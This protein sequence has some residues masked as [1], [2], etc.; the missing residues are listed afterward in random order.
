MIFYLLAHPSK[1]ISGCGADASDSSGRGDP[2]MK[3]RVLLAVNEFPLRARLARVLHSCGYVAALAGGARRE[4]TR[5]LAAAIVAPTSFDDNGLA[6]ARKLCA[7]GC[8]VIV[9]TD[10]HEAAQTGASILPDAHAFL[11]QPVDEQRL[12]ALL[13]E[14]AAA[15]A[16]GGTAPT[17]V[18]RFEGRSLDLA[19][20]AFVDENGR[21][22]PLTHSEFELLALFARSSGQVL[23]RDQLR[24]GV[25][26][27]DLE[28]YDRSI[29]V[30]VARLRRKIEPNAKSPRFILTLPGVGYK[31]APRVLQAD[32]AATPPIE[33]QLKKASDAP[34]PAE[35]RQLSVLACQIRGWAAS[36]TP[37]DPEDEGELMGSIHRACADVAAR[38]RGVVARV[39][40]DSLLIYFGYTEAQEHDPERAVRVGLELIAAI[41]NLDL[42][43]ALHPHIGIATSLM[44][45]GASSGPPD[46]FAATG[47][48][49]NLALHLQLAAPSDGVLITDRTR[50]LVGD[51]FNYRE[52]EPIVL[53]DGLAPVTVWS[54]IGENTNAGRFEALRRPGML[55]LVGRM[56]EMDLLRRCWSK[57][58]TGAGQVVVVAGEP[59]IGKSRLITE[60]EE[61]VKAKPHTI[62]RYFGSPHQVDAP[63]YVVIAELQ[64]AA[65]FERVDT[66]SERLAKI[67]NLLEASGPRGVE[68]TTPIADLL[69]LSMGGRNS[70]SELTP[71]RRKER[72][73]AALMARVEGLA[74]MQ[75]VLVVVEDVQWLDPTS[76]EFFTL[77]V[78]R[79]SR[80]PIMALIA[81]RPEFALPW[82]IDAHV[83]YLTLARLDREAARL[84]VANVAGGKPLPEEA[85]NQILPTYGRCAAV[86]RRADEDGPGER[87]PA[88]RR[89]RVRTERAATVPRDPPNI[90][91]FAPCT[92]RPPSFRE[93]S[94]TN[95]R[96]YWP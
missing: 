72:T 66:Q 27:R 28:A 13:A 96:R 79:L 16:S 80:L 4:A 5:N 40:G 94:G 14:I 65:G 29:D 82:P 6:V 64:K 60:F 20:H 36:S 52:M 38:F 88:R 15:Q 93:R 85:S 53:A 37:L 58:L 44:M 42:P 19:R 51:F 90:A 47:Q 21:E 11:V 67:A 69:S 31:F 81:A 78:T 59:G 86:H 75:P 62:L 77:L 73:L 3:M 95:R 57:T 26:G 34:R 32:L 63:L 83:T 49:L 1:N 10:S 70:V 48:A 12:V 45:V 92:I 61:Q 33:P 35:H 23:S 46:E 24:I 87:A 25:S 17:T 7:D 41:R 89:P 55:E 8:K 54:V 43:S 84:V 56:Q 71:R 76:L 2:E 91:R 18:L 68:E 50:E 22:V 39:L 74:A 9:L 30:L